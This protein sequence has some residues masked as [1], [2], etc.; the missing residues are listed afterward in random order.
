MLKAYKYRL[1]PNEEQKDLMKHHFGCARFVYNQSLKRKQEH[2]KE[3]KKTLSKRELQDELVALKKDKNYLWLQNV[4]SQTLLA[5]LQHLDEAFTNFFKKRAGFPK[6]KKKY[7]AVCSYQ[8]PQHVCVDF[9][10]NIVNLP[11]IKQIKCNFHR[12]FDGKI[13]TCTISKTATDKYFISI[14]VEIKQSMPIKV[15]PEE[16]N[17]LGIDVG[18]KE[19]VITSAGQVFS[20]NKYLDKVAKKIKRLQRRL[21]KAEKKSKNRQKIRRKLAKQHEKVNNQR[22]DTLHKVTKEL[23]FNNH[24][25]SFAVENLNVKGMMKNHKLSKAIGDCSFGTLLSFLEYKCNWAGKNLIKIDRWYPSSKTCSNCG[26]V[27]ENLSLSERVYCCSKCNIKIDRD[28]NAA[29]NIKKFAFR[30]IGKGQP[31]YKPVDHAL[32]GV[33]SFDLAIHEKKQEAATIN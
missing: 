7:S 28:H 10:K 32:A 15:I 29:I 13:K 6:F 24:A 22:K 17:T 31:D 16:S 14:L 12:K 19:L 18:V 27:K 23:V 8:C 21:S 1:Y 26:N 33:E 4:N 3:T 2:Y 11:K 30:Q 20:N 5:S 25:T 9:E